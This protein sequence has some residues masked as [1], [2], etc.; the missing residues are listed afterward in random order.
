MPRIAFYG[1]LAEAAWRE[2][3]AIDVPAEVATVAALRHWLPTV[4]PAL[5]GQLGEGVRAAIGDTIVT[6]SAAFDGDSEIAFLPP[7]SGG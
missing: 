5:A 4:I 3:R 1:R 2:P 6:D 7:V